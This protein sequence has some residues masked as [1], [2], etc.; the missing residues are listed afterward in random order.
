MVW[1]IEDALEA[2]SLFVGVAGNDP[3]S[4]LLLLSAAAILAVSVGVFGILALGGIVGWLT[5][6]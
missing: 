6:N 2:L 3:L 1:L 4:P 5:P